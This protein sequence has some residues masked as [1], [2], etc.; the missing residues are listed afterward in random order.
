MNLFEKK[1]LKQ[2]LL[3]WRSD[4]KL[5]L[6]RVLNETFREY[7]VGQQQR[8]ILSEAAFLGVR[9]WPWTIGISKVPEK[10]D[11]IRAFDAFVEE[12]LTLPAERFFQKHRK[13]KP[14][15]EDN[16]KEH[17]LGVH[18][19]PGALLASWAPIEPNEIA[20]HEYLHA[21][22]LPAPLAVRINTLKASRDEVLERWK[23]HGAMAS[24]LSSDGIVFP[25]RIPLQDDEIFARGAAEVQ[26]EHSQLVGHMIGVKPGMKVLD[27]CAGAGGKSL[28]MAA[29]MN[30][31][32]E[33]HAYDTA[34]DKL[35]RLGER[36][37]NA[38]V[39]IVRT[40]DKTALEKTKDVYDLVLIDAP[41]SSLG[42]LRRNPDRIL[43]WDARDSQALSQVQSE[44]VLKARALV[45]RGGRLA[46]ATC[47]IRPQENLEKMSTLITDPKA[48]EEWSP[49]QLV[50][51]LPKGF[52]ERLATNPATLLA[53]SP[54]TPD[55]NWIQ[56]G[57]ES[58]SDGGQL[59]G[60]LSGDGFFLALY[61]R[62]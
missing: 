21:S 51:E 49:H 2:T 60:A 53:G 61:N 13:A 46:Y 25:S 50:S 5:P 16:R 33:I 57:P 27:L 8:A 18:G 39:T 19:V 34:H 10:P 7:R 22:L 23:E 48:R 41:C 37:K 59:S 58:R 38:G 12:L 40:V 31:Q 1:I 24:T 29:L 56:W 20:L 28:H 54:L 35:K 55:A 43:K 4:A 26:D 6:D 44:L 15:F 17:L 30:N 9:V 3:E 36:T 14:K 47:T 62:R 45:K 11:E 52:Y 32:G 42:T